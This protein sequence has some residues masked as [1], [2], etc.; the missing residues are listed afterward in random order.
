MPERLEDRHLLEELSVILRLQIL[1]LHNLDGPHVS[2]LLMPR[3]PYGGKRPGPYLVLQNVQVLEGF[4]NL[5]TGQFRFLGPALNGTLGRLV[6]T[7]TGQSRLGREANLLLIPKLGMD[8]PINGMHRPLELPPSVELAHLRQRSRQVAIRQFLIINRHPPRSQCRTGI[9]PNAGID[10]QKRRNKL[11]SLDANILPILVMEDI[12]GGSNL[13]KQCLGILGLERG[14]PP[15][16]K[17]EDDSAAPHVDGRSVRYAQEDFG[18]DEGGSAASGSETA[19][20]VGQT[21]GEAE[22]AQLDVGIVDL[23]HQEEVFRFQVPMNNPIRMDIP[24]SIQQPPRQIPRKFF[25]IHRPLAQPIKHIPPPRQLQYQMKRHGSF[26]EI[27]QIDN[28]IIV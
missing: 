19:G 18:R 6:P 10:L 17:V 21:L 1:P 9:I 5:D 11:L 15:Q 2:A 24:N 25:R 4:A 7:A 26:K 12:I 3:L 28:P 14:I 16:Q 8:G 27:N 13:P 20:R 22:V 23:V